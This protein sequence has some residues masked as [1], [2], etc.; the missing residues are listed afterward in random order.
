[1]KKGKESASIPSEKSDLRSTTEISGVSAPFIYRAA[2]GAA[3]DFHSAEFNRTDDLTDCSG[4]YRFFEPL[5]GIITAD[6]RH[7]MDRLR[8]EGCEDAPAHEAP[9]ARKKEKKTRIEEPE[10]AWD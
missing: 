9:Q 5:D 8:E 10:P 4:S 3:I 2:N 1:M 7:Q 6:M